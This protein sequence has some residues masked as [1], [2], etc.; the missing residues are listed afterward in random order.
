MM[1]IKKNEVRATT[2]L[3]SSVSVEIVHATFKK[4]AHLNM[5]FEMS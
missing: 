5:T 4:S 3:E 2:L 1:M